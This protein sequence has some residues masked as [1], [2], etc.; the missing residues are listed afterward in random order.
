MEKTRWFI[1]ACLLAVIGLLPTTVLA[2]NIQPCGSESV[3][4]G[5]SYKVSGEDIDV[6]HGPSIEFSKIVN[7]K[8]SR[9]LKSTHYIS[10]DSSVTVLEECSQGK[11]S[12]IRVTNPD[13][14]SQSHQGWVPSSV[15]RGK[16]VDSSGTEIFTAEDFIF[17]NKTR[18]YKSILIAGVNRIHRENA[19]CKDIDPSSAYISDSRG[20]KSD[21]VFF[22]TCGKGAK[23]FNVFFSKSDVENRK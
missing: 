5:K 16:K 10:I 20:S 13:Y 15:L 23:V 1:V 14:F 11:W 9:I 17:D 6:R 3:T 4:T 7:Q 2:E 8:A 19:G 21:P 12:K 22:V 18:P